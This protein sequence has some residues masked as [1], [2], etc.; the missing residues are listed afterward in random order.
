VPVGKV[1]VRLENFAEIKAKV[2]DGGESMYGDPM[3]DAM[4]V[5]GDTAVHDAR[6]V[7]SGF[8]VS[9]QNAE[10]IRYAV[11][12][13]R[14]FPTWVKVEAYASRKSRRYPRGY[15]YPRLLNYG[16]KSRHR[17]WLTNA[18]VALQ[19]AAK[20][21]LEAVGRAIELKWRT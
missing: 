10:K 17:G 12:P 20:R 19:P 18:I 11:A 6:Q 5:I 15:K 7:A 4:V 14:P 1:H 2:R 8:R 21:L 9:G 3:E 16:P 13:T